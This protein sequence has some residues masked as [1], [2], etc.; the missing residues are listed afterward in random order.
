MN[1]KSTPVPRIVGLDSHPDS[2]TAA[3]LEGTTP[4]NALT[5]KNIQQ[6]ADAPLAKVGAR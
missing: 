1:D 4:S 6:S 2:F 3:V 5:A